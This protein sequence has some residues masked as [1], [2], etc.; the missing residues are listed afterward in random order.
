MKN[1]DLLSRDEFR[2]LVFLRDNHK[3]VVCGS[4]A[5]DAHHILERRLWPDE[6]YYLD[7]GASLCKEHHLAC[8]NTTIS[9]ENIR[10]MC[11][12]DKPIIPEHMYDDQIYDKWGNIILPSGKR[13][14]GELYFDESVQKILGSSGAI[15]EFTH[16]VKYPRTYHLPWS[17]SVGKDDR[18]LKSTDNFS[19]KR[20]IVTEKMDGENTTMYSDKIHARSI[21]GRSHMSRDWAKQ[22]WSTIKAD[23]PDRWRICAE[24]L[25][26]K[27]SIEYDSLDSFLYGFSVWNNR[28]MCLGWDDAKEWFELL[29]IK[30]VNVLYDGVFDQDLIKGIS[31]K[32]DYEK[33]EGYVVRVAHEFD[34]RDFRKFVAKFVRPNHVQ[35]TQHWMHGARIERN[36][37]KRN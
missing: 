33:A 30:V 4:E 2:R 19:G 17:G 31:S 24:N 35:T 23:I 7:N 32:Q 16:H 34:Y 25:W 9:V 13:L 37:L 21:D 3:C 22:F 10:E 5:A 11:G 29:G 6:G 12:I 15:N 36:G 20:V 28:N 1:R 27:H 14:R 18:V 26:A 8:E